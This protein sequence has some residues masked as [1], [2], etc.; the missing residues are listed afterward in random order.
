[1]TQSP[2]L[3]ASL[4]L[5]ETILEEKATALAAGNCRLTLTASLT[6]EMC[7]LLYN[8]NRIASQ[9]RFHALVGNVR[10]V[11][12]NSE[13]DGSHIPQQV[14]LSPFRN[15]TYLE[16]RNVDVCG[17]VHLSKL[18]AQLKQLVLVSCV[19]SLDDVLARCGG[20]KCVDNFL[21]S[22]L[23]SLHVT[24]CDCLE[25]DSGL[26]LTPWLKTL[27]LSFN[28]LSDYN[29]RSLSTLFSVT[30]ITLNFNRLLH[31]PSLAPSARASLKILHLRQN[32]L[33]TLKG[34]LSNRRTIFKM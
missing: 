31:V 13:T 28:S 30:K 19:G 29:I 7:S 34:E 27:D 4:Q 32:Q 20:D 11:R 23:H 33:E 8:C 17:L 3:S 1:M 9:S 2:P 12:V 25:L 22:E 14:Y 5:I 16:V 24:S 18:R 15:L 10:A 21:W 26:R 6:R